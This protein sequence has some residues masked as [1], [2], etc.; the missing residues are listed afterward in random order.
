[1]GLQSTDL[2]FPSYDRR[3]RDL[4][5]RGGWVAADRMFSTG[6]PSV[7]F[8][9]EGV[10]GAQRGVLVSVDGQPF[11]FFPAADG[12]DIAAQVRRDFLPRIEPTRALRDRRWRGV[13][14]RFDHS[15]T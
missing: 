1:M 5:P 11:A 10:D 3:R 7:D 15:R 12:R 14:I 2:L 9:H 4:M 8:S 13:R 6:V